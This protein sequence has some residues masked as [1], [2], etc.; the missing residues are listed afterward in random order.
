MPVAPMTKAQVLIHSAE[1]DAVVKRIY[2]LGLIQAIEVVEQS[3][4]SRLQNDIQG[5]SGRIAKLDGTLREVSHSLEILHLYDD[6]GREIIENFVTLKQRISSSKLLD[7]QSR[8]DFLNVSLKIRELHDRLKHLEEQKDWLHDDME[9]LTILKA[10]PFPLGALHSTR[11]VKT[12]VGRVRKENKETL[13]EELAAH[14]EQILWEE[15]AEER[16]FFYIFVL[17]Y[18]SPNTRSSDIPAILERHGVDSLD[19]SHFSSS[20]PEE[21]RELAEKISVLTTQIDDVKKTLIELVLHKND[22]RIIEEYLLNEIE[23]YKDLQNFAETQKVYF[24][25]GWMKQRDKQVL[26]RGLHRFYECIDIFYDD[27]ADDDETVPVI[28][29]NSPRIQPFELSPGC[30]GCPNIMSP[31]RPPCLHRFSF[32]FLGSV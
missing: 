13:A 5:T 31:I 20:I 1:S 17:Y 22:F 2:E 9:L 26:E 16:Q 14:E 8:F 30:L 18:A 28:L 10:I 23:R 25:E 29:E 32:S 27:P 4:E 21:L 3:E 11:W 24:V 15:L 12:L 7:V 6:S 19:L